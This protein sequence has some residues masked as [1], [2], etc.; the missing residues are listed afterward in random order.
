[1][2]KIIAATCEEIDYY[3]D[4]DDYTDVVQSVCIESQEILSEV[5]VFLTSD[6]ETK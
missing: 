1:M 3:T 2:K 6:G 4:I 5:S